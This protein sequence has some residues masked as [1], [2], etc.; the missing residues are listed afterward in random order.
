[1]C[2]PVCAFVSQPLF[3]HWRMALRGAFLPP[4]MSRAELADLLMA[5]GAAVVKESELPATE[6]RCV[7]VCDAEVTGV[8]FSLNTFVCLVCLS[9]CLCLSVS[10]R[11]SLPVCASVSTVWCQLPRSCTCA[12][13]EEEEGPPAVHFKWFLDCVSSYTVLPFNHSSKRGSASR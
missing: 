12:D 1:M 13:D 8:C 5:A 10:L 4:T 2:V 6:P 9:L 7:I 11:V 3:S